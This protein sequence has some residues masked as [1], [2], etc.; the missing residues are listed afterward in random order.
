[1]AK[2][3][4]FQ[5][6]GI[7]LCPKLIDGVGPGAMSDQVNDDADVQRLVEEISRLRAQVAQLQER[8]EQ[9]DH[10]AHQDSLIDL[11]NRRGF[12][13][14]LERLIARVHRYDAKAAMLYVDVDG[15]KIIN[16]SS[17]HLAGDQ[18]LIQVA[19]LLS[20]GVRKSDVVARIGGDEFGILL[21]NADEPSA[22]ETATRLID[23]IASCD[24]LHNGEALPLSVAIGVGM[25]GASDSAQSV[26]A[27]ADEEMYRRKVA[28]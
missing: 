9:L 10:L 17:G 6:F 24:F 15:L 27:R 26:M 7:A 25:I 12:L 11:P 14:E 4:D 28:A 5:G 8:V 19:Q 18:A 1:M 22:H 2:P 21:E 23:M 13:R 16:D 20:S 3:L